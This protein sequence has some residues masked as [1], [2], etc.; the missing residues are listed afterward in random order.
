MMSQFEESVHLVIKQLFELLPMMI[1][2][3][4]ISLRFVQKHIN[5]LQYLLNDFILFFINIS[6]LFK[7]FNFLCSFLFFLNLFFLGFSPIFDNN[8]FFSLNRV[9]QDVFEHV[10]VNSE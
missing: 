3:P 1:I 9:L 2:D 5:S 7:L 10:K 6:I 4:N 8:Q